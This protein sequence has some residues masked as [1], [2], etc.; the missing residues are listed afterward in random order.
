M[1]GLEP[2]ASGHLALG[3]LRSDVRAD[4]RAFLAAVGWVPQRPEFPRFVTVRQCLGYAADLKGLR[5]PDVE[6]AVERAADSTDLTGLLRRSAYRLSGGQQQ[7]LA[8]AQ[9]IIH[10]P[11]LLV[12]DEPT[13]GLDPVQ[14]L[15]FREWLTG[16]ARDH[17]VLI[18]THMI[19]DV[20]DVSTH[21]LVLHEGQLVFTGT[22][23]ALLEKVNEG[24]GSLDRA[25]AMFLRGLAG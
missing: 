14:R 19:E 18:S 11:A 5:K 7:R 21:A 6:G 3:R 13:A 8:I 25:T 10:R 24:E 4:R 9:A 1:L 16:Y 12:L 23:D 15:D 20:E 2:R 22:T 17:Q